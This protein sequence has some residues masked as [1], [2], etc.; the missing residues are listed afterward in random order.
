MNTRTTRHPATPSPGRRAF[1]VLNR[2]MLRAWWVGS[3]RM[4]N[5]WPAVG[6]RIFVLGHV[7]RNSGLARRTPLN[8][9]RVGAD[10]FCVAGFGA[11]SDWY[12]NVLAHP[13]VRVWLPGHPL[14][15]DGVVGRAG[16]ADDDPDR[17]TLVRQVLAASGFAAHL[18]G[19]HVGRIDDAALARLT[20]D[21]RLVRIRLD[22]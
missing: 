9:A 12:R 2:F 5:A 16:P 8:Y 6:G 14:T 3:G 20:A 4:L 13:Q 18:A 22:G 10:V 11:V 19:V 21:Y 7:G 17:T 1:R 15:G